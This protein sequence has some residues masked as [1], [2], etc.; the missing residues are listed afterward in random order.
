MHQDIC[1]ALLGYTL[2]RVIVLDTE[3]TGLD[4]Y[5]DEILSI[6]ITDAY[7]KKLFSSYVHPKNHKTWF[8]AER[9]NR[10]R[11]RDVRFSPTIGEIASDIRA[12]VCQNVLIV[13]YNTSFD[14]SFLVNAGVISWDDISRRQFDVMRQFALVHGE[15]KS[16]YSDGYMWS[17]LT[18]C[19]N[20]Y[21]YKFSAHNSLDDARAT[22]YCF[23]ALLCDETY[24]EYALKKRLDVATDMATTQ[25]KATHKNM[26]DLMNFEWEKE[27]DG[28]IRRG[29]VTKGKNK[30][31]IRFECFVD[32][33]FVG[34][35]SDT[36]VRT[37]LFYL[38]YKSPQDLPDEIEAT[39]KMVRS[40]GSVRCYCTPKLDDIKQ[41]V[42]SLADLE[43]PYYET[44]MDVNKNEFK[45]T[46]PTVYVSKE[47]V[48]YDDEPSE[49]L[50]G[51]YDTKRVR[52]IAL[53]AAALLVVLIVCIV[54]T[55]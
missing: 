11:L 32:N 24:Y 54:F 9:V 2:D 13:G 46:T 41:E 29:K 51:R 27:A 1:D 26:L 40:G 52:L 8:D 4:K 50:D 33:A 42:D 7:G 34:I 39:M 38:K 49:Q 10:I 21:G 3:T 14:M 36:S 47:S 16:L 5:N 28:S 15:E 25:T 55:R 20:Y 30:G 44:E 45:L 17:K 31:K 22:A 43:R 12:I 35:L 37:L 53:V 48:L 18:E 6:G 19:A 23:R